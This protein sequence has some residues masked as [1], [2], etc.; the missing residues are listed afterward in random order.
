MRTER[1][2]PAWRAWAHGWVIAVALAGT[3][4]AALAD[5]TPVPVRAEIDAM[6]NRLE[7]SH[8][9]FLRNGSWHDG[10]RAKSHL[11]D[12]LAYIEKRGVVQSS[13]QFIELAASRSS[14]SGRP[15][16]VRCDG[17]AAVESRHW[18]GEQLKAIRGAKP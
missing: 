17:Q 16:Q 7:A 6:L 13:E 5:P 1:F 15:Y 2:D 10:S 11:L 12:K 8:C 14:L 3:G 18:L 9:Q 4:G